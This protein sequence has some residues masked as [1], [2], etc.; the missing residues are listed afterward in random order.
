[1]T[2][3]NMVTAIRT[4]LAEEMERDERVMVLGEDVGGLGGV[5]RATEGLLD[6]FGADRVVDMPLA[7]SA[8]IGSSVGLAAAGLVPVPEIQFWGFGHLAYHQIAHQL[9]RFRYRTRGRMNSQVTIRAAFGGGVRALEIHS[10][11]YE[12]A[13][14]QIPGLKIVVP[15]TAADAKGLLKASIRDED[16]VLYLEP[17]RGYRLIS[18][19]VPEDP[20]L[21]VPLG[22]ARIARPGRDVTVVA[23]SGMIPVVEAAAAELEGEGIDIEIID[24]RTLVPLDVATIVESVARTGRAVVVQEGPMTAGFAAEIVATIGEETFYSLE[25]PIGR[26]CAPDTP[27][28]FATALEEYYVPGVAPIVGAVQEAVRE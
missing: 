5:F 9:A 16:P 6:Q 18:D 17:L 3:I 13:Y 24:L 11:A 4:A 21:L 10:D 26:V 14:A 7:E 20:D 23:W 1:M 27:Y 19:E 28:P 22:Q 25:A 15:S 8:I 12:S 2:V